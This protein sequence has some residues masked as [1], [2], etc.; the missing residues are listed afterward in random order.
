LSISSTANY[1]PKKFKQQLRG[2]A[3]GPNYATKTGLIDDPNKPRP[4]VVEGTTT[5]VNK[6]R[7]VLPAMGGLTRGGLGAAAL[8][9]GNGSG[10]YIPGLRE[11]PTVRMAREQLAKEKK[12]RTDRRR[13]EE[14]VVKRDEGKTVG[15]EY[16]EAAMRARREK[17]AGK[18]GT[19]AGAGDKGKGKG[20]SK[21]V[22]L[23][24]DDGDQGGDGVRRK[25]PFSSAAV[26]LI[27][28]DPTGMREEDSETKRN[29]V[30]KNLPARA[31]EHALAPPL[32]SKLTGLAHDL[33]AR[34]AGRDLVPHRCRARQAAPAEAKRAPGRAR[35]IGCRRAR[36]GSGGQEGRVPGQQ[37]RR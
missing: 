23:E 22:A 21:E 28:Y 4:K 25:R 3:A 15:G 24:S 8:A 33:V 34:A 26:R 12:E 29:R 36:F 35:Q 17:E 31:V 11:G 9:S 32:D 10:G 5:Y 19:G 30:S 7:K 20:R 37:R 2:K 1:D 6:G 27:G 18:K 16:V 14:E 13:W